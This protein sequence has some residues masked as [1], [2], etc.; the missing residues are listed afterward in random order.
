[1]GN[2]PGDVSGKSALSH[3]NSACTYGRIA[4]TAGDRIFFHW[5]CGRRPIHL[6]TSFFTSYLQFSGAEPPH[7][8]PVLALCAVFRS[9]VVSALHPSFKIGTQPQQW[10]HATLATHATQ[11]LCPRILRNLR[12][13]RDG[14]CITHVN[15]LSAMQFLAGKGN[16]KIA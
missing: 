16:A 12:S 3:A 2:L 13:V 4:C 8:R 10:Q 11:V 15:H 7:F 6:S 14:W 9:R 1:M 5:A